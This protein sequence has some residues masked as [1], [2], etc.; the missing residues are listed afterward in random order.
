MYD[1]IK[2]LQTKAIQL[3]LS[4]AHAVRAVL[5]Q[6]VLALPIQIPYQGGDLINCTVDEAFKL[7]STE[8]RSA[9]GLLR[10]Y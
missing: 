2:T 9:E 5:P 8:L 6:E 1:H 7:M 4:A 10:K 3:S